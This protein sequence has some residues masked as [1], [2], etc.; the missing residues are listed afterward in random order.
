MIPKKHAQR[1]TPRPGDML[2]LIG[3]LTGNDGIHG[4]TASSAGNQMDTAS[5]QIGSPLE[6]IKFRQAIIELRDADCLRAITDLGAAGLNSA[7]G[8]M[9]EA[10]GVWL[11]TALVPLKTKGLAMWR[12]LLSESQER[13]LLAI[14]P[15]KLEQAREILNRHR[16]R[17]TVV[18][19]FANTAHYT[20]VHDP[21]LSEEAVVNADVGDLPL[22]GEVGLNVPYAL[23]KD[24]TPPRTPEPPNHAK[25]RTTWPEISH[26]ELLGLLT[27]ILSDV[28]VADQSFAANRYDWTV[29]GRGIQ[30]RGTSLQTCSNSSEKA[31]TGLETYSTLLPIYNKPYAT[32]FSTAFNPWLFEAHPR[33]AARQ[34][35]LQALTTQVLAGVKLEDVC[36][37]DNFYTPHLSPGA[38]YWLV[39]MVEELAALVDT[40]GTPMISGKDSSAG[41]VETPEGIISVPPAVYISALGKVPDAAALLPGR[42][43]TPG[44][45]LYRIGP[46]CPSA[47]G[48]VAARALNIKANDVDELPPAEHQ[49]FLVAL[50]ATRANDQY[51][52]SGV[53]IG[54]GGALA[55]LARGALASGW[56]VEVD[57]PPSG[58]AEL[59]QEHRCGAIVEVPAELAEEVDEVSGD[60]ALK[61]QAEQY[62]LVALRLKRIGRITDRAHEITFGVENILTQEAITAW[63][64]TFRESLR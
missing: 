42:W 21:S 40:F 43:R 6:E 4:A 37:C 13:M 55:A 59:L 26:G 11:N 63:E 19:R 2:M 52:V 35:F 58:I 61:D 18:G 8:E 10:C 17:G 1:G 12:I 33:L 46:T 39:E 53:N 28:E 60:A 41:S 47:A 62:P 51:L 5:V 20:V 9:G 49:T 24:E 64:T 44:N 29:Q 7:V 30:G 3:G 45:V 54:A 25:K 31:R 50:Q 22:S 16:C 32:V 48:T 23:L 14:I 38:E 36:L 34:M 27:K 15:E 56:G 57:Q